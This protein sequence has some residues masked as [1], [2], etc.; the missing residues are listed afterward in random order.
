MAQPSNSLTAHVAPIEAGAPVTGVAF[1]G[2]APA[3]ALGDGC[4]LLGE[5]GAQKRLAAHPDAG[6]LAIASAAGNLFTGGDD[7]RVVRIDETGAIEEIADEK[8][9][10]I[11]A[12]AAREDGRL[13]W[14]AGKDVRARDGKGEMKTFAAPS[15]VRGLAYMPKGY[16]IA[17]AHYNGATLW[18]P[19]ALAK[20]ESF[21]WKGSHLD[22]TISPDGRFIVTSMQ[23]NALHAW[24]VA[25]HKDLRLAGYPAKTRSLSWSADGDWLATS[26]AEGGI[27]WPFKDKDGPMNKAPREC[28]IRDGKAAC[29]AFHPKAP[30]LA[31]GYDDGVILLC[32]LTDAAEILVRNPEAGS[33]GAIT[34]LAWDK[35]GRRLLFGA[36]DG[37]AGLLVMP[38]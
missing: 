1:I 25:D 38:G 10:W 26:G 11:D 33:A 17:L 30:V 3:L 28:G 29:V 16:R 22:L 4:V 19:N 6:V 14:S 9:R 36:A 24:R 23:E 8:G 21:E 13:V 5:I 7:G 35:A 34:S 31:I 32:R 2:A 20:P 27:V 15:S 12:I 18:F 37:A